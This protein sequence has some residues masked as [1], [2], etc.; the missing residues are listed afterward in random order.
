MEILQECVFQNT[1]GVYICEWKQ[2]EKSI[3][4]SKGCTGNSSMYRLE[5]R[6]QEVYK[7]AMG[8]FIYYLRKI[9]TPTYKIPQNF[10]HPFSMYE[11]TPTYVCV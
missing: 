7:N 6:G 4:D 9:S 2:L 10:P 8:S 1:L 11:N 5:E 3:W